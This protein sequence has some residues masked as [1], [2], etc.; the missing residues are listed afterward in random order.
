MERL[1]DRC[2]KNNL[3]VTKLIQIIYRVQKLRPIQT[4]P[5]HLT[6]LQ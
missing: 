6:T 4:S 2:S 5:E 1:L 3:K